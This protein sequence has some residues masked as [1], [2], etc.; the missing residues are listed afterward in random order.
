ME[1]GAV[2]PFF[3]RIALRSNAEVIRKRVYFMTQE[4]MTLGYV[5]IAVSVLLLLAIAAFTAGKERFTAKKLVM[6][7]ML[8]AVYVLLCLVG[9]IRLWWMNVSV[10]TLPLIL[11]AMLYGPAGGTFVGLLGS[12]LEQLLNYG[13]MATTPLWLVPNTVRG[14]LLGIYFKKKGDRLSRVQ[15]IAALSVAALVVT[16][17]NTVVMYLDSII[18]GYYSYA[19]VFGGAVT[20]V[21]AGI[22]TALVMSFVAPPVVKLLD[23]TMARVKE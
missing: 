7:A 1:R 14:L 20:R 18:Q 4:M 17:L 22:V 3:S 19:Y 8:T 15:L 9:T 6:I 10:A 13:L 11:A 5:S 23:K 16:A 12:F 21:I 2:I